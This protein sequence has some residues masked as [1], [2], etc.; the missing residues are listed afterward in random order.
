MVPISVRI[1]LGLWIRIRNQEDKNNTQN[2]R[3][4]YCNNMI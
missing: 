3:K 1:L 4:K 2:N